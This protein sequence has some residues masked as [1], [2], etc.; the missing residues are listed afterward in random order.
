MKIYSELA[1]WWPLFSPPGEYVEEA[2]DLLAKIDEHATYRPRTLLELG[3]GGGSLASHLK[4]RF[5]LTL[6]DLSPQMLD[7]NRTVNPAAEFI[8]GDMRSLRLPGRT[9]DVVLVHDAIMYATTPDDV[10]ATIRTAALHC[11]PGGLVVAVP[12]HVRETFEPATECGGED[13]PD[14]RGFRYLQWTWDPD[15]SDHT[16]DAMYSFLLR[17][18]DG[19]VT[20]EGERHIEGLFARADWLRWMDAEGLTANVHHDAWNRDVLFGVKRRS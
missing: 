20:V 2:A 18:A 17:G 15:P 11:N 14:G 12:D 5:E 16:F 6:T 9:F 19:T 13:S 1:K 4:P 8:V 3:S 10:I 7:V